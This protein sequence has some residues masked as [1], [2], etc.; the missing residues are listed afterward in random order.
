MA[1]NQASSNFLEASNQASHLVF[2]QANQASANLLQASNQASH[3]VFNQATNL[4]DQAES[5]FASL[6]DQAS[7]R[8]HIFKPDHQAGSNPVEDAHVA[9]RVKKRGKVAF[10]LKMGDRES[11]ELEQKHDHVAD[12]DAAIL[13]NKVQSRQAFRGWG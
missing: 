1:F 6:V 10:F 5:N 7:N 4:V 9:S 11:A 3:L 13:S 8:M 2:N 12:K